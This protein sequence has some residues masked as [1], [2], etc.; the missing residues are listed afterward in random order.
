MVLNN[1]VGCCVPP[2]FRKKKDEEG[3]DEDDDA[4]ARKR[5]CCG[6]SLTQLIMSAG[7]DADIATDWAYWVSVKG[8]SKVPSLLK[9]ATHFFVIV[10]SVLYL[11]QVTE[12]RCFKRL[13]KNYFG[14]EVTKRKIVQ[15]SVWYE[16]IPQLILTMLI[17]IAE[18]SWSIF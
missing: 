4:A 18:S 15:W 10:S 11:M 5:W 3:A 17:T 12:G 13:F 14:V 8:N 16:D 9:L 1:L 2:R 7:S 6:F